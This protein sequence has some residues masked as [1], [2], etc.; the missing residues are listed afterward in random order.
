MDSM[1]LTVYTTK[2]DKIQ[3]KLHIWL[4]VIAV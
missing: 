4:S 2:I 3:L 1:Y